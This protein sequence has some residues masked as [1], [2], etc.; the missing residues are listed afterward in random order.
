M[1][2]DATSAWNYWEGLKAEQQLTETARWVRFW[3]AVFIY[4][5]LKKVLT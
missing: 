3:R 2:G 4:R 5:D 1:V